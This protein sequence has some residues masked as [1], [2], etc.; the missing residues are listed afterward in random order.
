[1]TQRRKWR[2]HKEKSVALVSNLILLFALLLSGCSHSSEKPVII[3]TS[4]PEF[5]SY[6]ELFN[7]SQNKAKAVIVYKDQPARALPPAKDEQVP[8]IVVGP[9]LKNASTRK[10]FTP[11]DYLFSEQKINKYLFYPQLID[12]GEFNGKQYLLPVS[13]NLP[14]MVFSTKNS[15]YVTTDHLMSMDDIKTA[16]GKFNEKNK[17]DVYTA[18]GYAPSWDKDFLYLAAKLE[19]TSFREK[20]TSFAWNSKA[21]LSTITNL[22]EW[23]T[24]RNTDT[25]SEQ[26]FQFKY[27][28]MPEYKQVSLGKSLF[29]FMTSNELFSLTEEQQSGLSFRWISQNGKVPIEDQ[30]ITMGLYKDS[31]N[32]ADAEV[33]L[34]WFNKEITQEAILKRNAAMHLDNITFGIAGG[35]SAL[36]NVNE[37]VYPTYYRQVLGNLPSSDFLVTPNILPYRWPSLKDKVIIPYLT[38]ST[39][40][41][42][43]TTVQSLEDRIA[44]WSKQYF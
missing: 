23:T 28:Y 33:F 37:K 32:S 3:W 26:N 31:K 12:Y 41:N 30:I 13:F 6:V 20:G 24:A 10:Y 44:D 8:D 7:S 21:M 29:A 16:A 9:W 27:L 34:T 43:S 4:S 1:M 42:N 25:T 5:A 14:A 36:K 18:M 39:N 17:S 11:V 38:A 15:S 22:R 2:V 40:T 19:G 35:F